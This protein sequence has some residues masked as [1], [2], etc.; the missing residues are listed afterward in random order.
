MSPVCLT[1]LLKLC[2][3]LPHIQSCG[4]LDHVPLED[5]CAFVMTCDSGDYGACMAD[6]GGTWVKLAT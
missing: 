2:P 6:G 5:V 1:L 3:L 4:A